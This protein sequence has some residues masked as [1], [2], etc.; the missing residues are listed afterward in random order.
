MKYKGTGSVNKIWVFVLVWSLV[1][2]INDL[3]FTNSQQTR[4]CAITLGS[5]GISVVC[6]VEQ[7]YISGISPH[8]SQDMIF[9]AATINIPKNPSHFRK[10]YHNLLAAYVQ[11]AFNIACDGS[12]AVNFLM[13]TW[14]ECLAFHAVSGSARTVMHLLVPTPVGALGYICLVMFSLCRLTFLLMKTRYSLDS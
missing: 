8:E 7:H 13:K 10:L 2:A 14:P 4:A 1:F 3:H 9:F 12:V 5:S 6:F 11:A